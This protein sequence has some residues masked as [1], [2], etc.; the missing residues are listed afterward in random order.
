MEYFIGDLI[1]YVII[2]ILINFIGVL[3]GGRIKKNNL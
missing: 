2:D 1:E 3:L